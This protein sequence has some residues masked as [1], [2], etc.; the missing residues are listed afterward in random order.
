VSALVLIAVAA[1]GLRLGQEGWRVALDGGEYRAAWQLSER[2]PQVLEGYVAK[3]EI[4][5]RAGDP[6]GA[7]SAAEA[8]LRIVPSHLGLLHRAAAAAIWLEH[9]HAALE[10]SLRLGRAVQSDASLTSTERSAWEA[11]AEEFMQLSQALVRSSEER[12]RALSR[13][14]LLSISGLGCAFG[15]IAWTAGRAYGRSSRPVS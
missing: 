7:R 11:A 9:E 10:Y 8:G 3:A 13:A 1:M 4:L 12:E 2:E 5:Y 6:V 15:L 14:R